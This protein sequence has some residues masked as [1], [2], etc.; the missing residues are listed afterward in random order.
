MQ[1][2]VPKKQ[3]SLEGKGARFTMM[4]W[5]AFVVGAALVTVV[6]C[7]DNMPPV[8]GD[9][10][11]GGVKDIYV[12]PCQTPAAGCPC[13]EAGVTEVCG[14]SYHY[15]GAYITCSKDYITC[16]SDGTWGPCVGSIV[17]G[18]D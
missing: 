14:T 10:D 13:A 11:S 12:P 9:N 4:R 1:R 16:Q 8:I 6:A 3:L 17:F 18:A 2:L 7:G 15:S 5:F